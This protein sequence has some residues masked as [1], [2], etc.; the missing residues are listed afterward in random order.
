MQLVRLIYASKTVPGFNTGDIKAILTSAK[1]NNSKLG[2]T[3]VLFF[4]SGFFLQ[5]LEGGREEVNKTY[6]EIVKDERHE[7]P[8]ILKYQ[9]ITKRLFEKWGMGF[10]PNTKETQP[11]IFKHSIQDSFEPYQI[12]SESAELMMVELS[13][14]VEEKDI[15]RVFPNINR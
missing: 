12:S 8:V 7:D 6:L 9:E 2:L 10:I 4:N 1:K 3:G 11:I 5:C 14:M 15:G 13:G